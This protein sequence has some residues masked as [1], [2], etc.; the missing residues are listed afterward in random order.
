[1]ETWIVFRFRLRPF[2]PKKKKKK[3]RSKRIHFFLI[4]VLFFSTWK[5]NLKRSI[6]L[7]PS[8]CYLCRCCRFC[9]WT[10]RFFPFVKLLFLRRWIFNGPENRPIWNFVRLDFRQ[11]TQEHHFLKEIKHIRFGV[12][13]EIKVSRTNM[14]L[15]QSGDCMPMDSHKQSH[16]QFEGKAGIR[17][18]ASKYPKKKKSGKKETKRSSQILVSS[19]K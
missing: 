12:A 1:M 8:V 14:V 10:H 19:L 5:F 6:N 2:R 9:C 7:H 4:L 18:L 3:Q 16:E 13:E 15:P 11:I 17:E